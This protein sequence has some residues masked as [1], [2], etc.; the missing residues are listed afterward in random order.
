MSTANG[1]FSRIN[2][3]I[4]IVKLFPS[5][6]TSTPVVNA[7]QDSVAEIAV[8]RAR[9]ADLEKPRK[10]LSDA[11]IESVWRQVEWTDLHPLQWDFQNI[12]RMRFA[13]ALLFP[14]S[15]KAQS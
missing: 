5:K 1:L 3:A 7:L 15:N 14:A 13:R 11:D 6:H 2:R 9:M 8:L 4:A 10:E 12:L